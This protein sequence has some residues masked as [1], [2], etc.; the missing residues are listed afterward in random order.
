MEKEYTL[1]EWLEKYREYKDRRG[2]KSTA[3]AMR[4]LI[5]HLEEYERQ[6]NELRT[7]QEVETKTMLRTA[8]RVF[9]EAF[10]EYLSMAVWLKNHLT[11]LSPHT[12]R[13]YYALLSAAFNM[14]VSEGILGKSPMCGIGKGIRI[15]A[16]DSERTYLD[17]DEVR[18]LSATPCLSESLRRA[19][20]FS[21]F[22]GLRI[23]DIRRLTWDNLTL[24]LGADGR[25][26]YR[27]FIVVKKTGHRLEFNLS[28]AATG[29][30][31]AM[32]KEKHIFVL[33]SNVSVC[34]QLRQWTLQAGISKHVTFHTARHTFATMVLTL[35]ADIYTVSKLLGHRNVTTTQI[36]ARIVDRKKDEAMRLFDKEFG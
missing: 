15:K 34:R 13:R 10:A 28:Q 20:L 33:P 31:P 36:Y 12:Q 22:T 18:T 21:C 2:C 19:F 9:V 35:G 5:K 7:V 29:C 17:M 11:P 25:Q 4:P 24:V 26:T 8:D 3:K 32:G 6:R 1:R 16:A 30:L 27:L 23:S 14:A